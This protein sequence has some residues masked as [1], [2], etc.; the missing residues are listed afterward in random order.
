ME[1]IIF[2]GVQ[3]SGK[4][5][6]FHQKF[7]DSHIRINLD[8]LK[9]RHRESLLFDACLL[10]KQSFVVDNTNPTFQ[11]RRR[12]I[13]KAIDAG[14]RLIGFYFEPRIE[15]ALRRNAKRPMG[16]RVSEKGIGNTYGRL[17]PPSFEEGFNELFTVRIT[18]NNEFALENWQD[19]V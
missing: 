5:T 6:F 9:T 17:I 18:D 11:D 7:R 19:E 13:P 3:A 10:M 8:M 12:Y 16:M 2:I 4:S 14:F 1:A 15:D